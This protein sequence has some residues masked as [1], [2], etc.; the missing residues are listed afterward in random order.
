MKLYLLNALIKLVPSR[1]N[2]FFEPRDLW[3]GLYWNKEETY[4]FA[5]DKEYTTFKVYVCGVPTLPL[6]MEWD[7][8]DDIPPD[9]R[10]TSEDEEALF[11]KAATE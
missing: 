6:V 7:F 8:P 10:V 9:C 11:R 4:V 1:V 5:E 2:V 3:V